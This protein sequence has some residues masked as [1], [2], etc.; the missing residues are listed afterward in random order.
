MLIK[1]VDHWQN[2]GTSWCHRLLTIGWQTL[3]A[4]GNQPEGSYSEKDQ[5]IMLDSTNISLLH[6]NKRKRH[7]CSA[8][9]YELR[10]CII[11]KLCWDRYNLYLQLNLTFAATKERTTPYS[12]NKS[13][14]VRSY[15][16]R[17][18]EFNPERRREQRSYLRSDFLTV[19]CRF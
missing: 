11:F 14:V 15:N 16:R 18:L 17:R 13:T 1:T 2:T 3:L 5:T 19:Y 9:L 12:G 8:P 4:A 10:R 6:N 7:F